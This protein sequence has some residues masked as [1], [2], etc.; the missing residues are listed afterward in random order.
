MK[1][2]I[3]EKIMKETSKELTEKVRS[4][5]NCFLK[6]NYEEKYSIRH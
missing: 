3:A 2:K 5:I 6:R 4:D 1:S